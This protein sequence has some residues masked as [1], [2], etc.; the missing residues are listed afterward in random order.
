MVLMCLSIFH[1]SRSFDVFFD[2]RVDKRLNKHRQAG[3]LRR[4][5]A[6]YDVIVMFFY[7]VW[8]TF[9]Y[10]AALFINME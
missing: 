6:H 5:Q 2:L 3:D 4:H 9:L 7:L 1:L 10:A 8:I